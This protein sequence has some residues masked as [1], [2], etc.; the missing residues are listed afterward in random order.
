M[1]E[2]YDLGVKVTHMISQELS[3]KIII[4]IWNRRKVRKISVRNS[5]KN[6]HPP[7]K[8]SQEPPRR[9]MV[10]NQLSQE[11]TPKSAR[12]VTKRNSCLVLGN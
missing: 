10:R 3:A 2:I 9:T 12:Q 6:P 1:L 8:K 11:P 4:Y 7:K 5:E